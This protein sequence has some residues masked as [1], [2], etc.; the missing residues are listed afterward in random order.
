MLS[1]HEHPTFI[2]LVV[3]TCVFCR[4]VNCDYKGRKSKG[5]MLYVIER[6][7]KHHFVVQRIDRH[8]F[9]LDGLA[10]CCK[11]RQGNHEMYRFKE[12][13]NLRRVKLVDLQD[14]DE[15]TGKSAFSEI[16]YLIYI[17]MS[18]FNRYEVLTATK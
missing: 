12:K 16:M 3:Y 13:I 9:L 2:L 4:G 1:L 8:V 18:L 7:L 6:S 14:D 10:V 5:K 15:S 11:P 17:R